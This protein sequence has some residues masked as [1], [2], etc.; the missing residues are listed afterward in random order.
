MS[1]ARMSVPGAT[2]MVTRT[3][4][5]SL[6]LLAPNEVVNQIMEYCLAWAARGRGILIHA[7]TVESNHYHL[8][9]TDLDGKLS[10]FMQEF[11]RS[12]ARCLLAYYRERFPKLR[13]DAIWSAAQ[14]FNAVLLVTLN[15]IVDELVYT[16]V[17]PVKDGLVRDYR[18]WPGFNTRPGD[19][20]L[21]ERTVQRPAYYF[22]NTPETLS[23]R[24]EKPAQLDGDLNAVIADVDALVLDCQQQAAIHLASQGRSVPNTNEIVTTSP[25]AAPTNPQR[26]G[27]LKPHLAAGGDTDALSTAKRALRGF[28]RAYREAW[29]IFKQRVT[30]LFPGGTLLMRRRYGVECSPLDTSF[31]LLAST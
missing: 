25:I 7:V 13:I 12:A 14:S 28:R 27:N 17:N 8:V 5:M 3:T 21:G 11:N 29:A 26:R 1:Q 4:V 22:K 15:A 16:Y 23:Y 10:E 31:C 30:A 19:W 2:Y 24:I 6:F 9:L 20:A 18:D